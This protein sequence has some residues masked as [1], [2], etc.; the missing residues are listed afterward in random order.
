MGQTHRR[1]LSYVFF[2]RIATYYKFFQTLCFPIQ[3][4]LLS[5]RTLKNHIEL[6]TLPS[7]ISIYMV[8]KLYTAANVQKI[9]FALFSVLMHWSDVFSEY[10]KKSY[11][12]NEANFEELMNSP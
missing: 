9:G 12:L 4:C 11:V 1:N 6:Q 3:D 2:L 8:D 5:K 10:S 7:K